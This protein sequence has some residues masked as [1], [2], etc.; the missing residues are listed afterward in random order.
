MSSKLGATFVRPD[1]VRPALVQLWKTGSNFPHKRSIRRLF[2][3]AGV[4]SILLIKTPMGNL[5]YLIAVILII[6]WAIGYFGYNA[7]GIIHVLLVIAI[8]A[9]LLKVIRREGI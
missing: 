9:I 7:G 1:F 3:L 8:I 5:L 2:P 4:L 6:A